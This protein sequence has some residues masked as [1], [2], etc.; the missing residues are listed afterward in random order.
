MQ[1]INRALE[2]QQQTI[3]VVLKER[4]CSLSAR[5]KLTC[6]SYLSCLNLN[7]RIWHSPE[8]L[9]SPQVNMKGKPKYLPVGNFLEYVDSV[10]ILFF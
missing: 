2:L 8:Y 10:A 7:I 1:S 4:P 9:I 3:Q 6:R 5:S